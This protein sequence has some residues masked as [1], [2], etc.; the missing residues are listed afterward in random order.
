MWGWGGSPGLLGL[1]LQTLSL[2]CSHLPPLPRSL[3]RWHCL[4]RS[5]LPGWARGCGAV[6]GAQGRP[7][8]GLLGPWGSSDLGLPSWEASSFFPH[9]PTGIDSGKVNCPDR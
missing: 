2:S 8:H 6:G 3:A 9:H 4:D 1:L 7:T 5:K